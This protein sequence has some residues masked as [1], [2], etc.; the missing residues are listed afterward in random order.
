ML[1][2]RFAERITDIALSNAMRRLWQEHI[3]WSRAFIVSAV[4]GS[5]DLDE[6]VKR[7]LRNPGD[8]A[9]VLEKYYGR[10]TA[11]EFQA[12][13]EEHLLTAG[14]FFNAV[15]EN[16]TK[17]AEEKRKEWYRNADDIAAFFAHINPYWDE[18]KWKGLMHE[19][20]HM[21]EELFNARVNH[22]YAADIAIYDKMEDE[23]LQMA[24]YMTMGIQRQFRL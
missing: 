2:R 9:K 24:D 3:M 4:D 13:L 23:A 15:L 17:K 11:D 20:L 19:H 7:L 21:L 1:R 6:V 8:F 16:D 12:L 14:D 5:K 10:R 18:E 22:N